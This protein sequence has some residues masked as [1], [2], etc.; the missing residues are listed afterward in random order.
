M[1]Y[2]HFIEGNRI[3]LREVRPEDV[4]DSYY[5]WMNDDDVT[6]YTESRFY[7][8]SKEQLRNYVTALDGRT[9]SVFLAIIEKE[10]Q[11]HIGNIKL[12]N[13]NWIHRRADI[14]IIIGDKQCWGK[15]YA[16]EAICLLS[17][18]AFQ[19]LNLHKVWAGCYID[20]SASIKAFE[21]A[22]FER[23]G[24][25]KRHVYYAGK[26]VDVVLMGKFCETS[27]SGRKLK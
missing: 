13:I 3:F 19:K 8:Y 16:S 10:S 6:D 22:G 18:Y 15:G 21:K 2:K 4:N 20:N 7:P 26:Y 17:D 5:H 24:V 23:E 12:G 11:C 1:E 25:H 9:D 14:G 27:D